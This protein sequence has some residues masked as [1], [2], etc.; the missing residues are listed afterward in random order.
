M[1]LLLG[2]LIGLTLGL[3][4]AGG[5]IF[6]VPLLMLAGL[7]AADAMQMSL[8]AVA[9]TASVG[10]VYA[11]KTRA[12]QLRAVLIFSATGMLAAPLGVWLRTLLPEAWLVASFALLM[13]VVGAIMWWR[14]GSLPESTRVVRSDFTPGME[15]GRQAIC[16]VS[17]SGRLTLSARCTTVL[18]G[19]GLATGMVS[20]LFGV[21]G[22]FLIVPVLIMVTD[23][24][25][26]RAVASSLGVI[27]LIGGAGAVG[28]YFQHQG[29]ALAPTAGFVLGSLLGM[30]LGRRL[31]GR[32]AGPALQRY[33]AAGMGL[34]GIYM[35]YRAYGG[36]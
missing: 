32:L 30:G 9:I 31:A 17:P 11:L 16:R 3:T 4:G 13:G 14:A 25:I 7:D 28:G 27:A 18:L 12:M 36:V 34:V 33:F 10:A 20:G 15:S 2:T 1:L 6:A 23:M 5:T 8:V 24:G 29:V 22:G 19:F 26:H 35:M 21:G